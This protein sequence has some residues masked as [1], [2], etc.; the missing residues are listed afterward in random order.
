M[1]IRLANKEDRIKNKNKIE[2]VIHEPEGRLMTHWSISCK[3][4]LI[5]FGISEKCILLRPA[6]DAW[7]NSLAIWTFACVTTDWVAMICLHFC[8]SRYW[9]LVL[10]GTGTPILHTTNGRPDGWVYVS[11]IHLHSRHPPATTL[12]AFTTAKCWKSRRKRTIMAIFYAIKRLSIYLYFKW[13]IGVGI[14]LQVHLW[15]Y[16][17]HSTGGLQDIRAYKY[18]TYTLILSGHWFTLCYFVFFGHF[19]FIHAD[20]NRT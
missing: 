14:I 1:L 13:P 7:I 6:K 15:E 12:R 3:Y 4:N 2:I 18:R 11:S 10:V 5:V 16:Y 8:T 9:R 17:W 20:I 19:L